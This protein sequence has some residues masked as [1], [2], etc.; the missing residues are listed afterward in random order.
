MNDFTL[1]GVAPS[2]DDLKKFAS[3]LVPDV[4]R[5][6]K[7]EHRFHFCVDKNTVLVVWVC[8]GE[9]VQKTIGLSESRKLLFVL[10]KLG[11][12]CRKVD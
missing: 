8:D 3:G 9:L 4:T 11:F 6:K 1:F 12:S 10:H 2:L 7:E 5:L